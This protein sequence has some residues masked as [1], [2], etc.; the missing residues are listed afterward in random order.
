MQ[1]QDDLHIIYPSH[2]KWLMESHNLKV[3][4]IC[5]ILGIPSIQDWYKLTSQPNR[6][7]RPG[8]VAQV[9]RLYLRHPERLPIPIFS[10]NNVIRRSE[11]LVGDEDRAH[12]L[13]EGVFDRQWTT[14]KSWTSISRQTRPDL[15]SSRLFAI[16]DKMSDEELLTTLLDGALHVYTQVKAKP[17]FVYQ[18]V[19]PAERFYATADDP[20]AR[21]SVYEL[22]EE[23]PE[24]GRRR[25]D[26]EYVVPAEHVPAVVQPSVSAQSS[27]DVVMQE[28][29][30][31]L[32]NVP[33]RKTETKQD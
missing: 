27:D 6:P 3:V 17:I 24:P 19:E 12:R 7:I 9:A 5:S 23:G 33:W 15:A 22:V 20:D 29:R 13:L 31:K 10:I 2:L 21:R 1:R 25:S 30:K 32:D 4:E 14:I 11:Y 18:G 26:D 8:A 28:A 16:L